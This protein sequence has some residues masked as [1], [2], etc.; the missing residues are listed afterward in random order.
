MPLAWLRTNSGLS[1]QV[2]MHTE[3]IMPTDPR[4][5]TTLLELNH[6][7]YDIPE[8]SEFSGPHE[9]ARL[10]AFYSRDGDRCCLIP[11]AEALGSTIRAVRRAVSA[12]LLLFFQRK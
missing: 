9:G 12:T 3:F 7:I 10:V 4:W 5:A 6:D 11:L 8:Y 1:I 2:R